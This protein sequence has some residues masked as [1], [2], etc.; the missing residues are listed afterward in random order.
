MSCSWRHPW[1]RGSSTSRPSWEGVAGEGE[2]EEGAGCPHALLH[3]AP[4]SAAHLQACPGHQSSAP[5]RNHHPG[6]RGKL[7]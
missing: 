6:H 3:G 4:G 1:P 5:G 7:A 2:Q